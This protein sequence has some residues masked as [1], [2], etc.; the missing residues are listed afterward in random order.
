MK[1]S[2]IYFNVF[3]RIIE[4]NTEATI[5]IC[6]LYEHRA[7][8]EAS[9]YEIVYCPMEYPAQEGSFRE[10][11]IKVK[12]VNGIIK[13]KQFFAEE[14]EHVL[15]LYK[16]T[17]EKKSEIDRF[18]LYS[19]EEDLFY[20]YPYKGDLHMHS[21]YSDG[22][23]T[24]AYVAASCRKIGLDFM[25]ITDHRTYS[26]S[27]E[28]Q[29]KFKDVDIDL[30]IF[31]GEEVHAPDTENRIHIV[32]FGG[33]FSVNE[34]IRKDKEKYYREV[35]EL[36]K[37]FASLPY[38]VER[39]QYASSVW[40]F[41][42]IREAGGLSIYAHPFY[43]PF[44]SN[45]KQ[46]YNN[47]SALNSYIFETQPFD[48]L[49][50]LGG[51]TRDKNE[52]NVLQVALYNEERAKGKKIPIVGSTDTHTCSTEELFSINHTIV[53]S[54]STELEDLKFNIQN[55]YSVAVEVI[56]GQLPKI[57]GPYR[58]VKY[59]Q[60]LMRKVL[61]FHDS[62]CFEEGSIMLDYINDNKEAADR[63]KNLKGQTKKLYDLYFGRNNCYEIAKYAKNHSISALN[64]T[65][66]YS[67]VYN[68]RGDCM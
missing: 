36:G 39:Y 1:T 17:D 55:L 13:V 44:Y 32:N 14:Q 52:G 66:L 29:E 7:F 27:I 24:P 37:Q 35:D 46:G 56:P 45:S 12:P 64:I 59:V 63:L 33:K 53:F 61:P 30:K 40:I 34:L 31:R 43:R 22:R 68:N 57:Y 10:N 11:T 48:A 2:S 65:N 18:S 41:N 58:L 23:E 9:E 20:K 15:I 16:V 5:T 6:P 19:V 4:A 3:P 26:P 60:F 51:F 54:P 38:N 42:K 21:Y 49:E 8:K 67:K 47:S 50:V 28:A 62:L 25:A